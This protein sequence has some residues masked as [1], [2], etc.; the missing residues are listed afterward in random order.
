MGASDDSSSRY[1][2]PVRDTAAGVITAVQWPPGAKALPF[3]VDVEDLKTRLRSHLLK[4]YCFQQLWQTARYDLFSYWRLLGA[5]DDAARASV[6]YVRLLSRCVCAEPARSAL[7]CCRSW[8]DVIGLR[9]RQHVF[10]LLLCGQAAARAPCPRTRELVQC[11]AIEKIALAELA[12]G[13]AAL[14]L[15]LLLACRPRGDAETTVLVL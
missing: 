1:P 7:A 5:P 2:S 12:V 13:R 6:E 11:R 3:D 10:G 14:L 15:G 8:P 9:G 4:P